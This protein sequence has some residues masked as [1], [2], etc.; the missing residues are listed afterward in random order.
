MVISTNF[1]KV[2]VIA[3]DIF[4]SKIVEEKHFGSK[5]DANNYKEYINNSTDFVGVVIKL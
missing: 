1:Y 2:I 4:E 3:V 5:S